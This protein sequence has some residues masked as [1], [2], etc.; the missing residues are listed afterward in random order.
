[1]RNS[2]IELEITVHELDIIL[3]SLTDFSKDKYTYSA[4]RRNLANALRIWFEKEGTILSSELDDLSSNDEEGEDAQEDEDLEVEYTLGEDMLKR[5][6]S[7]L[8][9]GDDEPPKVH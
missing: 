5:G 6:L 1:M 4:G 2:K 7:N 9:D 3:D 8:S